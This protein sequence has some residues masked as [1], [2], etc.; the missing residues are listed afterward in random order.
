MDDYTEKKLSGEVVFDGKL[1]KIEK[2]TVNLPNGNTSTREVVRHP[3][4]VCVLAIDDD[5]TIYMTKQY[6]YALA[7]EVLELP[8]GKIDKG[9]KP[10]EA[11]KRELKEET[12]L[13]ADNFVYYGKFYPASGYSDEGLYFYVAT[14]LHKGEQQLDDDEFVKVV[15][16]PL[17][18]AISMCHNGEIPDSKTQ[19]LLLR[20][21]YHMFFKE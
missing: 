11:A 1:L 14:D 4:A 20:A 12:G 17:K 10:L 3:G 16:M 19:A 13:T 2:D 5:Y 18:T 8:A 6:R 7:E 15:A 21:D 9:E